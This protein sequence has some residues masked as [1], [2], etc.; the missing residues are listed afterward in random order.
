VGDD[1]GGVSARADLLEV[2]LQPDQEHV[3]HHPD[4]GEHP[5]ERRHR[6]WKDVGGHL[7]GDAPEHGRSEEDPRQHLAHDR[8]LL[9]ER[10]QRPHGPGRDDHDG[11]REQHVHQRVRVPQATGRAE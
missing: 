8:G 1:D 7:G 4:L 10:E 3:D 9:E 6:R 11:Q 2:E 5:Q